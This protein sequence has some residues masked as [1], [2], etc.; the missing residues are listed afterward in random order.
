MSFFQAQQYGPSYG[1]SSRPL[2]SG[3]DRHYD[4]GGGGGYH[5]SGRNGGD[6]EEDAGS[7]SHHSTKLK[8]LL[9]EIR[10]KI[11]EAKGFWTRLPYELCEGDS[12]VGTGVG[13][14]QRQARGETQDSNSRINY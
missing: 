13:S 5:R 8:N 11:G 12:A 6:H 3:S 14:G 4:G 7:G 10:D 1:R 9:K 2:T